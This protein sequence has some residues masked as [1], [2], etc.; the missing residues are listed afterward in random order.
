MDEEV[1]GC[2]TYI[3]T[4]LGKWM[5]VQETEYYVDEQEVERIGR[6]TCVAK[7]SLRAGGVHVSDRSG[8]G[9][10][11]V[12]ILVDYCNVCSCST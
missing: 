7:Y 1:G 10:K 5:R 6:Y 3:G 9:C 8:T 2:M 11:P 12:Y 4:Y